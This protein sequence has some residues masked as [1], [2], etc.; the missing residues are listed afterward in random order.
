MFIEDLPKSING[1]MIIE[2]I[3][4]G[5]SSKVYKAV[6]S[7]SRQMVA[8]KCLP[9]YKKDSC[10]KENI[11]KEAQIMQQIDHPFIISYLET[12]EDER[13]F[14]IALEF[15]ERGSLHSVLNMQGKLSEKFAI[16]IITQL[17][18]T[19]NYLHTQLKV[20]HK[21]IKAEN[22][23]FDR[24]FNIK[25]IDFGF[26]EKFDDVD[27]PLNNYC[28]SPN[29][30]AP[31]I[32]RKEEF[33]CSSDIWSLGILVY[34]L[35]F[36]KFPYE[37]DNVDS[38]LKRIATEPISIP[39]VEADDLKEILEMTLQRDPSKRASIKEI[40]Q[41]GYVDAILQQSSCNDI[42]FAKILEKK[43]ENE[44]IAEERISVSEIS[45]QMDISQRIFRRRDEVMKLNNMFNTDLTIPRTQMSL[46]PKS[47]FA[48]GAIT[49][50]RRPIG[51]KVIKSNN[52]PKSFRRS[53]DPTFKAKNKLLDIEY[54][55]TC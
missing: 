10:S 27:S 21:D 50:F 19:L 25:L 16:K 9:K 39:E 48:N 31:E 38:L 3:G 18:M 49:C 24:Y 54:G 7:K 13:N 6:H 32:V 1:Y 55:N 42:S 2:E 51:Q 4:Y 40:L 33:T 37:D 46:G 11:E 8:L 44:E 14:Y 23:M 22:I 5:T 47:C 15:A 20:A 41:C 34:L 52:H 36:G 30:I 17:V 12:F 53:A 35:N 45:S 29:Y 26:A 43:N 28:G